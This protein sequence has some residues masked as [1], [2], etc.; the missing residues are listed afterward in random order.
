MNASNAQDPD[1]VQDREQN[2]EQ[3]IEQTQNTMPNATP[4][5]IFEKDYALLESYVQSKRSPF[6]QKH[7]RRAIVFFWKYV[8]TQNL[9]IQSILEVD[10]LLFRRYFEHLDRQPMRQMVKSKLRQNLKAFLFW[11][12]SPDL[13]SGIL[14]K[15]NYEMI[16]SNKYYR[17]R[18]SGHVY[19][20][21]P[22]TREDV[23]DCLQF[24]QAR[25]FRD[26]VMFKLL[27]YTGMRIGGLIALKIADIDLVNRKLTTQEK[28]TQVH[29]GLNEYCIAQALVADLQA[30]L[31][32]V[33]MKNPSQIHLFPVSPNSV[34][35]QLGK[36]KRKKTHPHAFRDALNT[37][38]AEL[39]LEMALRD[40]LMNHEAS[41]INSKHYL[42]KYRSWDEKL[43]LYDQYFPY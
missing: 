15:Y 11:I 39:G 37:R 36:W 29:N 40:I 1:Q 42:K 22:L 13:V 2:K 38:W 43:A 20:E 9:A 6:T 27:A 16:F 21:D 12:L 30:Y 17:F 4:T 34:R 23:L 3:D 10:P 31:L 26:G 14:P 19:P 41:S 5:F 18:E 8:K 33:Q 24:F 7:V 28:P 25:N 32:E 35:R